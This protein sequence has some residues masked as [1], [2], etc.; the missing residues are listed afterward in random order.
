LPKWKRRTLVLPWFELKSIATHM[1]HLDVQLH[2]MFNT[3][4]M[5]NAYIRKAGPVPMQ[6]GWKVF[7]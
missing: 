2:A 1:A 4:V 6:S 7:A 3:E 5:I